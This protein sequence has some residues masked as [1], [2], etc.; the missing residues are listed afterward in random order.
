MGNASGGLFL[1]P[2]RAFRAHMEGPRT[3]LPHVLCKW[4][5]WAGRGSHL[6][7]VLAVGPLVQMGQWSVGIDQKPVQ[8]VQ[9]PRKTC[10]HPRASPHA[11]QPL[12]FTWRSQ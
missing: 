6:G 4:G 12:E 11:A 10:R 1:S 3:A 5:P 7:S 9:V 8:L 2:G